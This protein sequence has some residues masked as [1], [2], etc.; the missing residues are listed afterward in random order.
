[1]IKV[2]EIFIDEEGIKIPWSVCEK[3]Q[4]IYLTKAQEAFVASKKDYRI[5]QADIY[6]AMLSYKKDYIDNKKESDN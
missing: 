6:K 5:G 1:M 2:D 4:D 3:M